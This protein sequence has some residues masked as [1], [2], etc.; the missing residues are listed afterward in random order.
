[1][2]ITVKTRLECVNQK[3]E[4]FGNNRYLVYL[5]SEDYTQGNVELISLL[6]KYLGTPPS[7]IAIVQGRNNP[8]KTVEIA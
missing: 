3:I 5:V 6:S 8:D 4:Q 1:M 7:R 2:K